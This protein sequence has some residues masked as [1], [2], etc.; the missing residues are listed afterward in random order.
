MAITEKMRGRL[1]SWDVRRTIG[2]IL[3]FAKPQYHPIIKREEKKILK[4]RSSR[5]QKDTLLKLHLKY[6]LKKG[7]KK[8]RIEDYIK[9]FD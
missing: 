6:S 3:F 7:L 2:N 4:M 5:K 9:K 8:A 1:S